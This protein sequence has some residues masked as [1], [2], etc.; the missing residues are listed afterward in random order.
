LRRFGG[1]RKPP[2]DIHKPFA[3]AVKAKLTTKLGKMDDTSTTRDSA[4]TRS[5]KSHIIQVKKVIAAGRKLDS[6]YAME[7][8]STVMKTGKQLA[9]F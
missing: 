1:T 9:L 5:R 8:K 7:E 6:Q 4:A 3:K 2:T